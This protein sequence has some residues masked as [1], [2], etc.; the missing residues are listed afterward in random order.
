MELQML[1]SRITNV[2]FTIYNCDSIKTKLIIKMGIKYDLYRNP[3]KKGKENEERYHARVVSERIVDMKEMMDNIHARCTL[4][5][6]DM[7]P[8]LNAFK[9][10]IVKQL[11]SGNRVHIDG[12]GYFRLSLKV[13]EI[14]TPE[15]VS[16][17]AIHF[18]KIVFQA[19]KSVIKEFG[20]ITFSRSQKGTH[21]DEQNDLNIDN[22]LMEYFTGHEYM[23]RTVFQSLCHLTRT[24]A[25]RRLD[26]LID[27][28]KLEK[29]GLK[30]APLYRLCSEYYQKSA[31]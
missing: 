29:F 27:E 20:D 28:G 19:E 17:E 4:T 14:R 2:V 23:T 21:S 22:K 10:E 11:K 24:T 18:K 1:D 26:K 9:A 3:V 8:T 15:N 16:S 13:P 12:L 25:L 31:E 7:L 30:N 6:E 5:S